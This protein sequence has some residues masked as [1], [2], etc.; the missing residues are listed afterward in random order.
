MKIAIMQPYFLPYLGYWQLI[1][2]ADVFVIFDDANYIRGGY[3]NRNNIIVQGES[4]LFSLEL[5]KASQYKLINQIELIN[6]SRKILKTIEM[7][8]KKAL[9]FNDIYPLLEN[10]F[11]YEEK[12]LAKFIGYS[13]KKISN[14]INIDTKFLYSSEIDKNKHL[15]GKDKIINI[16]QKLNAKIYIN[17]IGGQK[18]YSKKEFLNKKIN[19][20]FLETELIKYKQLKDKFIS[21]LSIIDIMMHNNK[22]E[23]K[24]MLKK[25]KLQ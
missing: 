10:L 3:I 13:I 18:L 15:K 19:L 11:T 5:V 8:Y 6:D 20:F 2:S 9:Y 4:K 25:Y 22:D 7:N 24:N 17:P 14:Y 16:C 21:N 12:N 1:N 23:I